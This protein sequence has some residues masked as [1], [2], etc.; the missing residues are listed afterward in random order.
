MPVPELIVQTGRT[1]HYERDG[2]YPPLIATVFVQP[3][4]RI[5]VRPGMVE[6]CL[7]ARVSLAFGTQERDDRFFALGKNPPARMGLK[8]YAAAEEILSRSSQDD[9]DST[10]ALASMVKPQVHATLAHAAAPALGER[11]FQAWLEVAGPPH[12][13]L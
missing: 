2:S 6:D 11:E 4:A 12:A 3:D 1:G 7:N 13:G 9:P 10:V 8:H 5:P